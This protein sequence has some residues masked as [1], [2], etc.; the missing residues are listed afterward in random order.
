MKKYFLSLVAAIIML[1]GWSL[2]A[3]TSW[4]LEI[5]G[6]SAYNFTTPLTIRQTGETDI[7]LDARYSTRPFTGTRSFT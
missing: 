6:G 7:K 4:T 5:M 1:P 2:A 3:E